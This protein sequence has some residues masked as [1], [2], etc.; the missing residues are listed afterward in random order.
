[1]KR[2]LFF[3]LL[4]VIAAAVFAAKF[5]ITRTQFFD[6]CNSRV[7]GRAET[8]ELSTLVYTI[9]N[10]AGETRYH[11][12]ATLNIFDRENLYCFNV[13]NTTWPESN[14][15]AGVVAYQMFAGGTG[16]SRHTFLVKNIGGC[17]PTEFWGVLTIQS[18]DG[19]G[20]ECT[21]ETIPAPLPFACTGTTVA[22]PNYVPPEV[23][24]LL[25]T[26][27]GSGVRWY[28][29]RTDRGTSGVEVDAYRGYRGRFP[30]FDR[31]H[32]A[33]D[34]QG[35]CDLLGDQ[36]SGALP[37][38]CTE[39]GSC[40][41]YTEHRELFDDSDLDYDY[42]YLISAKNFCG[43]PDL[44]GA[45]GTLGGNDDGEYPYGGGSCDPF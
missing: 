20:N 44:E 28:W 41:G 31:S 4:T 11:V 27:E 8:N 26:E 10:N 32:T 43:D 15:Q 1:M 23:C 33:N 18:R 12:L 22:L 45:E 21:P 17:P 6:G 3:L 24:T 34:S 39:P 40:E 2:V 36:V 37:C 16:Q 13:G 9:K 14:T 19:S 7:A 35:F 30:P 5:E 42:Y 25:L 38:S 29:T